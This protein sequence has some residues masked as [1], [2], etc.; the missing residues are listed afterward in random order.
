MTQMEIGYAASALK[1]LEDIRC[2]Y[3]EQGV[4]DKGKEFIRD[5]L[6]KSQRLAKF[7]ESGRVVPEF[8]M[9]FLRELILPPFRV[10]YRLE[11]QK[12][13][14]IRIWRSE[15]LMKLD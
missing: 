6:G 2:F 3:H 11:P 14:V 9:S 12:I 7:P 8:Q 5:I 15:R 1:D 13:R 4:P 10:V